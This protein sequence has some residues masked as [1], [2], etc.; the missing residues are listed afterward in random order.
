MTFEGYFGKKWKIRE[1]GR[2]VVITKGDF[3]HKEERG[4]R[5]F[6]SVLLDKDEEIIKWAIC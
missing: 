4:M 5:G 6:G 2:G 1:G 3:S